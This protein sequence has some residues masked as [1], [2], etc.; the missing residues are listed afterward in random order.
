MGVADSLDI[1]ARAAAA[2]D[3]PD[4]LTGQWALVSSITPL[5]VVLDGDATQTPR[6]VGANAAGPLEVGWRVWVLTQG[7]RLIVASAPAQIVALQSRLTALETGDY[8]YDASNGHTLR[9]PDGTQLCWIVTSRSDIAI[10]SSY[11]PAFLG[12]WTWTFEQAFASAPAVMAGR[13][14]YGTS[15]SWGGVATVAASYADMRVYDFYSRATGT[16]VALSAIAIGR[17]R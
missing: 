13:A 6:A 9:L 7:R 10:T 17:W 1:I 2:A 4:P 14:H 12:A 5:L 8:V 15:A 16:A 11:G 3:R